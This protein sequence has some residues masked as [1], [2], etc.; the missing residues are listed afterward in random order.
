L[1]TFSANRHYTDQNG[2]R[3]SVVSLVADD[4]AD[5]IEVGPIAAT[6]SLTVSDGTVIQVLPVKLQACNTSKLVFL[7]C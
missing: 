4:A 6:L 1:D 5:F 7:P 3:W 2:K